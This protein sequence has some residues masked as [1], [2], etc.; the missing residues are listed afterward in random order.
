[1][2]H[3]SPLPKAALALAL[4]GATFISLIA[5]AGAASAIKPIKIS[6]KPAGKTQI[7]VI[8]PAAAAVSLDPFD[9]A[10]SFAVKSPGLPGVQRSMPFYGK[11]GAAKAG[12]ASVAFSL[13]GVPHLSA[14]EGAAVADGTVTG[15]A[16]FNGFNGL[17]NFEQASAGTGFYAGTNFDLEPPDQGLAVGDKYVVEDVN[18][19]IAVYRTSG[20]LVAGP[21]PTN[22]FFK[23]APYAQPGFKPPFG[24]S[25]SDIRA[26]YDS[27]TKRFFIEEWGTVSDPGSGTAVSSFI[28]LAVSDT[29][30]PTKTFT[31]YFINTTNLSATGVASFPDYTYLGLDANGVYFSSNYFGLAGGFQ[32]VTLLALSK[33]SLEGGVGVSGYVYPI[34][35]ASRP[36][37]T[38]AFALAPSVTPPG[39]A[40][41]VAAGGTE[42]FADSLDPFGTTDTRLDVWALTNTSSLDTLK[43]MPILTDTIVKTETYGFPVPATQKPGPYP[44]GMSLGE[45]EETL[46]P[47]D[48]RLFQLDYANGKLWTANTTLYVQGQGPTG[49]VGDGIAYYVISPSVSTKGVLKASVAQQG[50]LFAKGNDLIYP[51]IAVQPA[52]DNAVFGFTLSGPDYFPSAAY[53][54]LGDGMDTI[55]VARLGAA[56]EDGFSGYLAFGGNGVARWGDYS[57]A[58]TSEDGAAWLAAEYIPKMPRDTYANWGTYVSHVAP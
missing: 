2:P 34:A 14:A 10:G 43:G 48:D 46:N 17:D 52:L 13:P 51:T 41:D 24:S 8:A 6:I 28:A 39:T 45:M 54:S 5:P 38:F 33:S 7:A 40:Y 26:Y 30:D 22:Q 12:Q 23:L 15:G 18:N 19:A 55:H 36:I 57:A 56:P 4:G 31:L 29:P 21:T 20:Q 16:G 27:Y 25:L 35:P 44:L 50:Y 3:P 11:P 58:V 53:A 37:S 47:D 42:F 49:R 1:M 32:G 9:L